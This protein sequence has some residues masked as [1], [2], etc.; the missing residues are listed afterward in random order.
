MLRLSLRSFRTNWQASASTTSAAPQ[1]RHSSK[2]ARQRSTTPLTATTAA[3]MPTPLSFIASSQSLPRSSWSASYQHEFSAYFQRSSATAAAAA[4]AASRNSHRP[5]P[6]PSFL[7][8]YR[9]VPTS[10][11]K[12]LLPIRFPIM[13]ANII[14]SMLKHSSRSSVQPHVS[15]SRMNTIAN[16]RRQNERLI[17]QQKENG[18]KSYMLTLA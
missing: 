7:I 16:S 2:S 13:Y 15:L 9:Q 3:R 10:P 1:R 8:E 17:K 11:E 4:A 14:K 6:P 12:Y 18:Q 5:P